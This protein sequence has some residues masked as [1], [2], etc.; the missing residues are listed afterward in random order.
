MEEQEGVLGGAPWSGSC[1]V[2]LF[3]EGGEGL[4]MDGDLGMERGWE[5]ECRDAYAYGVGNTYHDRHTLI[6]NL[7]M[8]R[9]KT[10]H[11]LHESKP[12]R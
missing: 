9:K 11:G 3:V 4:V 2:F 10:I 8:G 1:L 6:A 5:C 12:P 7:E